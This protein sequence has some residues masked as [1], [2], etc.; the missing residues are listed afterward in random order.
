L[1]WEL[2]ILE[3]NDRINIV[4]QLSYFPDL[5]KK[6]KTVFVHWVRDDAYWDCW[7]GDP[8]KSGGV[9]FHLF[10]H[11]IHLAMLLDADFEGLVTKD[12]TQE[13][14]IGTEW[15][16]PKEVW[17]DSDRFIADKDK[18]D[19][20]NIDTQF[21]YNRMYEAILEGKGIKPSD[22]YYLN[23]ILARNSEIFGYG[24]SAIGKTIKIGRELL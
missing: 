22:L 20:L 17:S 12:G 8:K 9:F 14:Y 19:L 2:P 15:S 23:W 10:I 6:A 16:W 5:P 18:Y 3:G 1:P 4:L 13:R 11:Y 7:Q 21:L 24:K